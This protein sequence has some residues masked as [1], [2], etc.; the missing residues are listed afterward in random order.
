MLVSRFCSCAVLAQAVVGTFTYSS[1]VWADEE[2]IGDELFGQL[3]VV[4]S[5]SR[6]N[7]SILNTPSAVTV[8]DK[9]MIEASGFTDI[10]DLMR[11]V[12]GFNVANINGR[13]KA[14]NYHG[15]G[16]EYP[17]GLQVLVNGRST[18]LPSLSVV[19]W[20]SLGVQLQDIERIEVVRGPSPSAYGSNSFLAAINI[21]TIAPELDARY[22]ATGRYGSDGSGYM[23]VR[24]SDNVGVS[25]YRISASVNKSNGYDGLDDDS[26][27]RT[28]SFHSRSYLFEQDT[29]DLSFAVNRGRSDPMPDNVLETRK[30]RL[31]SWF[32]Q[33]QWQRPLSKQGALT[34]NLYHNVHLEDDAAD[35]NPIGTAAGLSSEVFQ[36]LFGTDNQII[37]YGIEANKSVKSDAELQ[38]SWINEQ[39]LQ[40]I[41]GG[42]VR[43]DRLKGSYYA[44][45]EEEHSGI[46]YRA[47]GNM[48]SPLGDRL[49]LNLGALWE[50]DEGRH[51]YFSP[52]AS[53][54]WELTK[55][56]SIRLSAARAYR[57]PSLLE[58]N[59][60]W[61][62]A[63]DNGVVIDKLY[64]NNPDLRAE[65]IDNIEVGY[66][67]R[68]IRHP[69]SWELKA[70]HEKRSDSIWYVRDDSVDDFI[71]DGVKVISNAAKYT[72][73]GLEGEV[74]YRPSQ[75][76]FIRGH[77]NLIDDKANYTA[78]FNPERIDSYD[79]L[80]PRNSFGV[81]G[82]K[83]FGDWQ[84]S[85]GV[86]HLASTRWLSRGDKVA[87]H[88]RVDA[89]IVRRI[90]ISAKHELKLFVAGQALNGA[91]N[92]FRVD[93]E[94]EPRYY[95]GFT[96]TEF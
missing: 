69:L 31:T 83:E 91:Y 80:A 61:D 59:G 26:D 19:D 17:N 56:Q 66:L 94:I 45:I 85:L 25:N 5:A 67:G 12:P 48:Q 93:Q 71:G 77:F 28:L 14:V 24:A 10:S 70:Y 73:S 50:K 11:L 18:Y 65:K 15:G 62:I 4:V 88:T 63:L 53:L 87:S 23:L 42:A 32:G 34:F 40:F 22:A 13:V 38:Y 86:Y 74:M 75:R 37:H 35:S 58:R 30:N 89:A 2:L 60:D 20:N 81:L 49:T 72:A 68:S 64:R 9:H 76:T 39:G 33:L 29:L 57:L 7:Q 41:A 54:N 79:Q 1:S 46:S 51:D 84:V 6:L 47:F 8:I 3:P 36:S 21:I 43:Y 82:S 55:Q 95:I 52:R 78:R 16:W 96:L 90:P 27:Y 92:E 44:G